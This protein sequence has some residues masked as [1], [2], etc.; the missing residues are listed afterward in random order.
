MSSL[1]VGVI[2]AAGEGKRM[3][4]LSN[5]LP[6]PL[7][8]VYDKPIIHHVVDNMEKVGIEHIYIPVWYQKDKIIEYF[9]SIKEEINVNI[10]FI[11]LKSLP[12]GIALTIASTEEYISEPFMVILGDDVTITPSLKNLVDA[13]F[14][15]SAIV[16]EGFVREKDKK[17]LMST[18]C[19]EI[20]ENNRIIKIVE[21][22][23]QPFS[24]IRGCGVYVFDDNIFEYIKRTPVSRIRNEVEITDTIGLV[25]REGKAY[26]EPIHGVNLNINTYEDLLNAWLIMKNLKEGGENEQRRL[27][28]S[29]HYIIKF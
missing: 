27:S 11:R 16:V 6:K 8:P 25:A 22:P 29:K 9:N 13:F 3:G 28:T 7:F 21:K 23:K 4:Y 15:K 19:I 1:R 26:A 12:P 24:D 5:V 14:E 10:E 17:I 18:N 20:G 2:P